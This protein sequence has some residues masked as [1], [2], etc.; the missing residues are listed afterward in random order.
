[1]ATLRNLVITIL[2]LAGNTSI[3]AALR[4]TARSPARAFRL[5]TCGG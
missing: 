4:H 3:A 1:M 5:L 2:H